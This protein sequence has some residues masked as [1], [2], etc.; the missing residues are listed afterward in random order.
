MHC[1]RHPQ[2]FKQR[3]FRLRKVWFYHYSSSQSQNC[4]LGYFHIAGKVCSGCSR[5]VLLVR[6]RVVVAVWNLYLSFFAARKTTSVKDHGW[7]AIIFQAAIPW[8]WDILRQVLFGTYIQNM[9]FSFPFYT[10]WQ[11]IGM[12]H[13]IGCSAQVWV[14]CTGYTAVERLWA[15]ETQLH[16]SS[17]TPVI[18]VPG[19]FHVRLREVS[20]MT[21][22]TMR[23]GT[24]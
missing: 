2:T 11:S 23:P 9:W 7:H 20:P 1:Y 6:S 17:T 14:D 13:C 10:I 22:M 4:K 8:D 18:K 19:C 21:D 15:A 24:Q 5:V 3:A 12:Q 16:P